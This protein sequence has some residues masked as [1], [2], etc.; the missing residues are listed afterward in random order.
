MWFVDES[1]YVVQ[2]GVLKVYQ[3]CI[4]RCVVWCVKVGCVL[5]CVGPEDSKW[6]G[7]LWWE[8]SV[9]VIMKLLH[10]LWWRLCDDGLLMACF[11]CCVLVV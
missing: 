10:G 3:V 9:V 7:W 6:R 2:C 11:C 1:M 4:V 8:H 5:W